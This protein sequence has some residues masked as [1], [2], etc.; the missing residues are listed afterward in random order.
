M[1]DM[2]PKTII[3]AVVRTFA[4]YAW[5]VIV[6]LLSCTSASAA[7]LAAR[8]F[9]QSPASTQ[10]RLPAENSPQMTLRLQGVASI[11]TQETA[12]FIDNQTGLVLSLRVGDS[13]WEEYTLVRIENG[14]D[15][16]R[17]QAVLC[18][19]QVQFSIG[20]EDFM[21]S[22]NPLPPPVEE[23]AAEEESPSVVRVAVRPWVDP[24]RNP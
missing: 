24:N 18:H 13:I 3:F 10:Q 22:N 17:C 15:W 20:V 7:D 9:R 21:Q 8:T 14:S 16:L 4:S 19:G 6:P 1:G 23:E 2:N 5:C 12:Y 11:G